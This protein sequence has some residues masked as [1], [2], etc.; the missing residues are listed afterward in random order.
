[1]RK[2]LV[3]G[4]LAVTTSVVPI[5]LSS[6]PAEAAGPLTFTV[7]PCSVTLSGTGYDEL[8]IYRT[9]EFGTYYQTAAP[10]GSDTATT[11]Y[12]DWLVAAGETAT[13]TA[14]AE[15]GRRS[16]LDRR[17]GRDRR[18]RRRRAP[19]PGRRHLPG[20]R[21]EVRDRDH[22]GVVVARRR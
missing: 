3:A 14:E 21:P 9:D 4:V 18:R 20:L 13:F 11:D 7:T 8:L 15:I 19:Q 22:A 1:M 16:L 5:A 17:V 6:A 2:K 12:G 10:F